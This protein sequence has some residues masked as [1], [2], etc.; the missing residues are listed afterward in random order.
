MYVHENLVVV[1]VDGSESSLAA[2]RWASEVARNRGADVRVVTCF[3]SGPD[4]EAARAG[5][6]SVA[7]EALSKVDTEGLNVSIATRSGAAGEALVEESK[8]AARVVVGYSGVYSEGAG[9]PGPVTQH[10]TEKAYCA[11]VVVPQEES[12]RLPIRHIAVGVDGGKASHYA[13]EL[14]VRM[15]GRWGARVSVINAVQVD[16]QTGMLA[17]AEL[18]REI[19]EDTRLGLEETVHEVVTGREQVDIQCYAVEGSA[20]NLL[21]QFSTAVDLVVVG[22]HG[23]GGVAKFVFGSTAQGVLRSAQS[24][25]MVVP[26]RASA[27]VHAANTNVPWEAGY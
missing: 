10:V 3:A 4:P 5:A 9:Q 17:G 7:R 16:A 19:L 2:L 12:K 15:A 1:G 11:V 8:V 23:R 21:G 22:T 13:I 25:V 6:E 20:A 14:A 18:T 27:N 26:E 24:P